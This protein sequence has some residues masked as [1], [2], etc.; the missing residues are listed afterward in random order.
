LSL[1]S[2]LAWVRSQPAPQADDPDAPEAESPRTDLPRR[3]AER[4][5]P[6]PIRSEAR[7]AA[8][9]RAALT[10]FVDE[11]RPTFRLERMAALAPRQ[12]VELATPDDSL[13]PGNSSGSIDEALL[14][15]GGPE[16]RRR[17]GN[18]RATVRDVPPALQFLALRAQGMSAPETLEV[19][20][21]APVPLSGTGA[22]PPTE[23]CDDCGGPTRV[24]M[25]DLVEDVATV[26]CTVCGFRR[27]ELAS[28]IVCR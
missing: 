23:P 3:E 15:I 19:G 13:V 25:V 5:L 17:Y 4:S 14:R 28:D 10:R 27:G 20:S 22:P 2:R 16:S 1:S 24:A 26:E 18:R 7:P 9:L 12:P 8:N 11:E 21:R 6:P